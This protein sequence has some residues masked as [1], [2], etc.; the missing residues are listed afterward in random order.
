MNPRPQ[1]SSQFRYVLK[2]RGVTL[3]E[4]MVALTIGL[5]IIGAIGSIFLASRQS[6]RVQEVM[7]RMQEN[8]R[9]AFEAIDRDVRMVGFSGY[10]A[11]TSS[12]C[13]DVTN[14]SATW[15]S[16]KLLTQ[17]LRGY[18]DS[19]PA[20]MTAGDRLRGDSFSVIRAD[21][22]T[23]M[24][25]SSHVPPTITLSTAHTFSAG[26]ILVI[27][28]T[29]NTAIFQASAI[30]STTITHGKTGI[31][32]GNCT[33]ELGLIPTPVNCANPGAAVTF[34]ANSGVFEL[35]ANTYYIRTNAAGEP[36]LY[37]ERLRSEVVGGTPTAKTI[38]E[39]LI[40]GVENMQIT[41]GVDTT[42]PA[43]QNIDSYVTAN[44]VADW[45]RVLG[46]R[47]SLLMV[48][49]Q[50][51]KG[52]TSQFQTYTYNGASTTAADNLLRKVFT[53]TIAIRNRL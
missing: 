17:P 44:N 1:L 39:E 53:T 33:T 41:Y 7:S 9:F 35:S 38:A 22:A 27:S 52:I 30:T 42:V 21:K 26:D 4:L 31:S 50:D 23:E 14:A 20:D 34:A 18:E 12:E 11:C 29:T 46:L 3:I 24:T 13:N 43:D 32:P 8:A 10:V 47:I 5:I 19:L 49:R 6:F 45:S 37:R 28:G 51:E 48:S 2:C 25:V 16:G 40:D 15:W 36:A